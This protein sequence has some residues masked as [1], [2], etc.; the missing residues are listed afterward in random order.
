ML[1]LV[2]C[3]LAVWSTQEHCNICCEEFS[4]T[5]S[6]AFIQ[7]ALH[8]SLHSIPSFTQ[9]VSYTTLADASLST[10]VNVARLLCATA[11]IVAQLINS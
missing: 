5:D 6:L 2:V 10:L 8:A 11:I 9:D 1:F 4:S 7:S 3:W